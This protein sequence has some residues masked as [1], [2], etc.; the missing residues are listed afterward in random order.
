MPTFRP[1]TSHGQRWMGWCSLVTTVNRRR[2]DVVAQH[3][4]RYTPA[5]IAWLR[6]TARLQLAEAERVG[7]LLRRSPYHPKLKD[8]EGLRLRIPKV[9]WPELPYY[10]TSWSDPR[11]ELIDPLL[12]LATPWRDGTLDEF[13]RQTTSGLRGLVERLGPAQL[14]EPHDSIYEVGPNGHHR[15]AAAQWLNLDRLEVEGVRDCSYFPLGPESTIRQTATS[16][17]I[18][19]TESP[20]IATSVKPEAVAVYRASGTPVSASIGRRL[21]R[22][23]GHTQRPTQLRPPPLLMG[24]RRGQ[25]S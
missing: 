4:G 13:V 6:E 25:T 5:Q 21:Q 24:R 22:L 2:L 19:L 23:P 18:H 17:L 15:V 1:V 3:P 12:V 20:H 14:V 11:T 10:L 8:P 16:S 7:K 9:E